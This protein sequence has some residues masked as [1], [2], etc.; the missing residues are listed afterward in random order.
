MSSFENFVQCRVVTPF[1]AAATE[2][3]LFA[4]D[5]PH[6]LPAEGGGVLVL[7]DSPYR[8]SAL[9]VIRY[10]RR[11][12][13]ALYEVSRAQE[14]TTAR[15]WAGV[16]FCYQ[17]LTAGELE[18]LLGE[19]ADADA[20]DGLR[21]EAETALD[22]KVDK[23]AGKGLSSNDYTTTE[24]NKLANS[25][26][27]AL[28][29]LA[30]AADRL[31][32]FTGVGALSLATITAAA[33]TLLAA[34]NVTGQQSALGLFA[35]ASGVMT[36]ASGALTNFVSQLL[37]S[38]DAAAGR[39]TLGLGS[40]ATKRA[41]TSLVDTT[42]PD[43][44][45][46]RE[47]FGIGVTSTNNPVSLFNFKA[48]N[49]SGIYTAQTATVVNG[50]AD[51][52]TSNMGM[53]VLCT[54]YGYD[55]IYWV[56]FPTVSAGQWIG[57]Y[58]PAQ[59]TVFW[60]RIH[61]SGGQLSLGTTAESARTVLGLPKASSEWAPSLGDVLTAGTLG[62]GRERG[63]VRAFSSLSQLAQTPAGATFM[64]NSTITPAEV[65]TAL[66]GW[67]GG[68]FPYVYML[69]KRDS[70]T[71]TY[72]GFAALMT[73]YS[74]AVRLRM[75]YSQDGETVGVAHIFNS[76]N[77]AQLPLTGSLSLASD[78][79]A[80]LGIPGKQWST[81]YLGTAPIVTSDRD[82]KM[83]I[84]PIGDA[85]LDA[86]ATLNYMQYR[87]K[88]SVAAKGEAARTHAGLIAQDIREAFEAAGLDPFKYG[89][90]CYDEW[91]QELREHPAEY[92]WI[93]VPAVL[94]DEGNEVEP[95]RQEQ[96]ELIKEAWTEVVRE[97]GH[98]YSVRYEEAFALECALQRRTTQRL[99]QRLA[100]LES[101]A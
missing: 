21:Q 35:D 15:D 16:A 61:D 75:V 72:P 45:L 79:A 39:N 46:S 26:L 3:G 38:A 2:I 73:G 14:G 32:Y 71:T 99:E 48:N 91:D 10:G 43:S 82:A 63:V 74:S 23:V 76:A 88:D 87:L 86:W 12:G 30:G 6:R 93:T 31:P 25:N 59:D 33:R 94:D 100:A 70:A 64:L 95:E 28:V 53:T 37:R 80:S 18:R 69:G 77:A 98:R 42:T 51:W 60:R 57:W 1:T 78:N 8:P 67:G 90:L 52:P 97:A 55:R 20:L 27:A 7:T 47:A 84:L 44:V 56:M 9:E 85:V 11:S 65:L 29:G 81:A 22:A 49:P 66:G 101:A 83:D 24:K 5:E 40:A 68:D 58:V 36:N 17:A 41:M 19:K 62:V 4:A 34:T 13:L 50:A 89:V 96:G 54:V 92:E